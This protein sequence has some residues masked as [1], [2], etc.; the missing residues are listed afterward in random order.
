MTPER[1]LPDVAHI[2]P[3]PGYRLLRVTVMD[4]NWPV[5]GACVQD[6]PGGG[7][8]AQVHGGLAGGI[9][10]VECLWERIEVEREIREVRFEEASRFHVPELVYRPT[11]YTPETSDEI[12]L[13][14]TAITA[15]QRSGLTVEQFRRDFTEAHSGVCPSDQGRPDHYPV[16]EEESR[17]ITDAEWE[18]QRQCILALTRVGP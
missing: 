6:A 9:W 12:P 3:R 4:G 7:W 1:R 11:G 10:R 13:T 18:A 5:K 16:R 2:P 8:V 17:G 15:L 14:G